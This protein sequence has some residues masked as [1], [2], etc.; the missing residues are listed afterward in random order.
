MVQTAAAIGRALPGP[1][2]AWQAVCPA[3]AIGE[4]G[5]GH[6]FDWR[7]PHGV[8]PAFVVRFAGSPRAYLNQC[9]HIGVEL[10]W[11][12]GRFFDDDRL[13]LVCATH[14]AMYQAAD[15]RCAGGPCGGRGLVSLQCSE[16]DGQVWV[17]MKEEV[18]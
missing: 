16:S 18:R 13:Y 12:P 17:L 7:G 5:N 6:R 8:A 14:G 3:G 9:A 1:G 10:D 4:G 2:Q 11:Q 15:G